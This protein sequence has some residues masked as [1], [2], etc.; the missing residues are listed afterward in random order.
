[1]FVF[2]PCGPIG[3]VAFAAFLFGFGGFVLLR[4]HEHRGEGQEAAKDSVSGY[5]SGYV[6]E[7]RSCRTGQP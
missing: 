3:P 2:G 7:I 1:M 5:G 4:M 6:H